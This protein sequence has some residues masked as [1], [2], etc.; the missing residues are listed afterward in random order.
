MQANKVV[1]GEELSLGSFDFEEES[2]SPSA[3]FAGVKINFVMIYNSQFFIFDA[4]KIS[5]LDVKDRNTKVQPLE[6]RWKSLY[7]PEWDEDSDSDSDSQPETVF[8][9][10]RSRVQVAKRPQIPRSKPIGEAPSLSSLSSPEMRPDWAWD[11]TGTWTL[12][13]NMLKSRFN[14]DDNGSSSMKFILT[15][16]AQSG[17]QLWATYKFG[18]A[19]EG[20][21]RFNPECNHGDHT[22][23]LEGFEKACVLREGVW[24]GPSPRGQDKWRFRFRGVDG[25]TKRNERTGDMSTSFLTFTVDK[26]GRLKFMG[27]ITY[28]FQPLIIYGVKD[29][30]DSTHESQSAVSQGALERS[31]QRMDSVGEDRSAS[32]SRGYSLNRLPNMPSRMPGVVDRSSPGLWKDHPGKTIIENPPDWAWNLAGHWN[33]TAPKLSEALKLGKTECLTMKIHISN[34]PAHTRVGRQLWASFVFGDSLKGYMRFCPASTPNV[35]GCNLKQFDSACRLEEGQWAGPSEDGGHE[36]W[37]W[38]W[39]GKKGFMSYEDG[40]DEFQDEVEFS[41]GENGEYKMQAIITY[42]YQKMILEAVKDREST[43]PKGN[44]P[45]ILSAWDG[46][47]RKQDSGRYI[48]SASYGGYD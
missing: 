14:L 37:L 20:V 25:R 1:G 28:E 44:P 11:L 27:S 24:P 34:Y 22:R 15:N 48:V 39:R 43:P 4:S 9:G 40:S 46:C 10:P 12:S 45:S 42:G 31:W 23:E 36:K 16:D 29:A 5:E 41:T 38:R 17:R 13:S 8:R 2:T 3:K 26:D 6:R 18:D 7:N 19:L 30:E 47:R 35:K 33:I 32:A 21:M